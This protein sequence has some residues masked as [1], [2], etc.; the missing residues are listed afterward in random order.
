MHRTVKSINLCESVIQTS[1][2]IAQAHGG[3]LKVKWEKD[4]N[5]LFIFPLSESLIIWITQMARI[6]K[7]N[8]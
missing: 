8:S 6:K 5:L 4:R 2:D 3:Q 7:R 1:Y